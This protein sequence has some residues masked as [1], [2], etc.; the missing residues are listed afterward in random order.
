MTAAGMDTY[1]GPGW[2]V[3]GANQTTGQDQTGRYVNGFEVTYQLKSGATG[4][5]FVPKDGFNE[6]AVRAAVDAAARTL[7]NVLNI[8]G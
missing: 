2:K 5:V 4:S 6:D 3:T 8:T 1:G 7:A